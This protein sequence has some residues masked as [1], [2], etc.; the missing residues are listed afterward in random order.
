MISPNTNST[1]TL[2]IIVKYVGN[3][4][5]KNNGRHSYA[6][7]FISSKVTRRRWFWST[8]GKIAAAASRSAGSVY[9]HD[10]WRCSWVCV[11]H[12]QTTRL[13]NAQVLPTA[14]CSLI[15]RSNASSVKK[16][17]NIPAMRATSRILISGYENVIAK[18]HQF[19]ISSNADNMLLKIGKQS[20]EHART[21]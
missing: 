8:S 3:N 2:N 12:F 19:P 17:R 6:T 13:G 4:L 21:W 10:S 15:R 20:K 16:P 11:L 7:A 9:I 18:Y 5:S 1:V 14:A